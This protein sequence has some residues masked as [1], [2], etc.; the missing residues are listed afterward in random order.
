MTDAVILALVAALMFFAVRGAVKH[1]KGESPCCGGGGSGLTKA[2][3]E[4]RLD[5]PV[6]GRKT[7]KISGMH[8]DH[9]VR[10]VTEAINKIDGASA[11]VSLKNETAV[12]SYDRPVDDEK[13]RPAKVSLKSETAVVSYDRPVE[14]EKIRRAVEDA[15]FQVVSI[16][17]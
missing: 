6:L 5:S 1:F 4:K 12:I 16:K 14:D 15:G 3:A 17:A 2:P 7:V 10:S 8:C 11:K 13:I 9:C